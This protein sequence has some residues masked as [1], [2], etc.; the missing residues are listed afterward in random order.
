MGLGVNLQP[1]KSKKKNIKPEKVIVGIISLLVII[2]GIFM[3]SSILKYNTKIYPQVWVDGIS[4]SGKTKDQAKKAI[5]QHHDDIINK[6]F[7]TIKVNGKQYTIIASKLDIKSDYIAVIDKAYNIGREGNIFQKYSAITSPGNKKFQLTHTYNYDVV[8]TVL[9]NIVK[10]IS[11]KATNATIIRNNSGELIVTKESDGVSI[12]SVSLKQAIKTKINNIETE[13]DLLIQPQLV[14][15]TPKI[16]EK[17]LVGIN[18]RISS[19]TTNFGS[20]SENRSTN[21]RVAAG[22][23][24][25]TIVM[26]GEIFSFNDVVGERSIANGYTIAKGIINNKVVDDIGGGVCQVSTTLYNSILRTNIVSVERYPHTMHS[27]YIGTGLDATV[28]Y[29]LLDYRFKN[30]YT[31]PIYIESTVQNKNVTFA[32]YSNAVLNNKKYQIIN[33]VVGNKV[34]VYRVTYQ[35]GKQLS[36]VLLYTDNIG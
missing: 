7:I 28:A 13:K 21:I 30:T 18:T 23:I 25:G 35:N 29:G 8:D 31:Y 22:S 9:K 16:K 27:S 11:K 12:D 26:P 20:S 2:Q 34:H 10:D 15:V 24:N 33:N 14:K 3:Y 36:K 32:V 5:I 4:L 19:A 1:K 6:K 17:D